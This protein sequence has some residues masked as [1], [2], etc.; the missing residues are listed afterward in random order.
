MD[1]LEGAHTDVRQ[2]RAGW[3]AK[4]KKVNYDL[5]EMGK[6]AAITLRENQDQI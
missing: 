2:L 5:G 4:P 6:I 3:M 1:L